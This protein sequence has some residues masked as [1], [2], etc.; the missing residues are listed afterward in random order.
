MSADKRYLGDGVYAELENGMVKLMTGANTIFLE[1]EVVGELRRYL[2]E[3][4]PPPSIL[5]ALQRYRGVLGNPNASAQ[6]IGNTLMMLKNMKSLPHHIQAIMNNPHVPIDQAVQALHNYAE[7]NPNEART[8]LSPV[9]ND[10]ASYE[11]AKRR[12]K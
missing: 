1:A 8:N 7:A 2:D 6:E 5:P 10:L 12:L 9:L 11:E 3:N 4:V